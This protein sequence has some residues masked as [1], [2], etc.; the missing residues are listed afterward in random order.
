MNV[1]KVTIDNIRESKSTLRKTF[2]PKLE[3]EKY[4]NKRMPPYSNTAPCTKMI[5]AKTQVDIDV[6][7]FVLGVL[8]VILMNLAEATG[9]ESCQPAGPLRMVSPASQHSNF[10]NL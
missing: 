6:K 4:L 3:I 1:K 2:D 8:V 5:Q 9:P 7:D 10:K